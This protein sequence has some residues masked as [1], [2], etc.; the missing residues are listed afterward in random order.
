VSNGSPPAAMIG[1]ASTVATPH[2]HFPAPRPES[3]SSRYR[4]NIIRQTIVPAPPAAR[5]LSKGREGDG[6]RAPRRAAP[7]AASFTRSRRFLP[8][9]GTRSC[10]RAIAIATVRCASSSAHSAIRGNAPRPAGRYIYK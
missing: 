3:F 5:L 2:L 4:K 8:E 1:R 10:G 7:L 9:G 6:S